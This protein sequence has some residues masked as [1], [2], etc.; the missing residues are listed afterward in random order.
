MITSPPTSNPSIPAPMGV[1]QP[2]ITEPPQAQPSVAPPPSASP[3]A[4]GSTGIIT[5]MNNLSTVLKQLV[6]INQK[7]VAS[8][9]LNAQA[10]Q[11]ATQQATAQAKAEKAEK[12]KEVSLQQLEQK[13]AQIVGK[14]GQVG[15]VTNGFAGQLSAIPF[16][17]G[18]LL[19]SQFSTLMGAADQ[20]SS[21]G[22]SLADLRG[23]GGSGIGGFAGKGYKSGEAFSIQK[24]IA[25]SGGTLGVD[26]AI[27]SE[28][29]GLGAGLVAS[30]QKLGEALGKQE[31]LGVSLAT[32][33]MGQDLSPE[34][35]RAGLSSIQG[36]LSQRM[37][38]D[39]S[40]ASTNTTELLRR[41]SESSNKGTSLLQTISDIQKEDALKKGIIAS[42]PIETFNRKLSTQQAGLL[43]AQQQADAIKS[44]P[45]LS[46]SQQLQLSRYSFMG[47]S[48]PPEI[49][50]AFKELPLLLGKGKGDLS[51]IGRGGI[52]SAQAG[53][54][55]QIINSALGNSGSIIS[56]I[57]ADTRVRRTNIS[58]QQDYE[59]LGKTG[60]TAAQALGVALTVLS[61]GVNTLAGA[62]NKTIEAVEKLTDKFS[63]GSKVSEQRMKEEI[64]RKPTQQIPGSKL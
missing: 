48:L 9:N 59:E 3:Q 47:Q 1:A 54:E 13:I 14:V 28:Q 36:M 22:A 43:L 5:A 11:Q 12:D 6:E 44:R 58:T 25:M 46:L 31:N 41:I 15:G 50:D 62:M 23:L 45:D 51:V 26:Q 4:S 35:R 30:V 24:A 40:L 64:N 29:R 34:Q 38:G 55:M 39:L 19:A 52:A 21:Y 61:K 27:A 42:D 32:S 57:Q 10:T 63:F 16:G 60:E 56:A 53:A 33:L 7:L 37:G 8:N 17:L 49:A 20:A 18:S 2:Q